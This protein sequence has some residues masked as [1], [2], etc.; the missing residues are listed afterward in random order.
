MPALSPSEG[1]A[2]ALDDLRVIDLSQGIAG[3]Y[4]AKLLADCGAEVI[5][6]EPPGG[7]Y[8]RALGPF[9]DD[10]PHHDKGGLFVHLTGN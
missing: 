8:A 9:P 7:D 3:P 1:H 2:L 5:K 4:C 10:I 6:I